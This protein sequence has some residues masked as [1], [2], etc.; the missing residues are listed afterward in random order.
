MTE[1]DGTLRRRF[2]SSIFSCIRIFRVLRELACVPQPPR[3]KRPASLG[4]AK[5]TKE[6]QRP[7]SW[8]L[9]L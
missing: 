5:R 2:S 9:D 1:C 7:V 6:P 4:P 3:V 8:A